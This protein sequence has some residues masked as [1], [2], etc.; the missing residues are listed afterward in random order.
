MCHVAIVEVWNANF[1]L[2]GEKGESGGKWGLGL[3]LGVG[4]NKYRCRHK[5]RYHV[6][7]AKDSSLAGG[8][9][10]LGTP[11]TLEMSHTAN[12]HIALEGIEPNS[13]YDPLSQ[14]YSTDLSLSAKSFWVQQQLEHPTQ[15]Y[16]SRSGS[17]PHLHR[18]GNRK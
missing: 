5:T 17:S 13:L 11:C 4:L 18:P 16:Y 2:F 12:N 10:L 1:R 6:T 8:P 9:S 14:A 15:V 7:R 3:E